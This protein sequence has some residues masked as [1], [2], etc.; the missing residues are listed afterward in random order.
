VRTFRTLLCRK[1][2]DLAQRVAE[3][4]LAKII[5]YGRLDKAWAVHPGGKA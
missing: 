5:E 4:D 2:L 3:A 1:C